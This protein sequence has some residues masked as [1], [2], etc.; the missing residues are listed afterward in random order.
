[1]VDGDGAHVDEFGQV[2]FVWDLLVCQLDLNHFIHN[3][4]G[5]GR[6]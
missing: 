5:E 4:E 3:S 1:M 6:T 2:V